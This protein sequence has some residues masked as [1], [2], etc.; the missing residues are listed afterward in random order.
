MRAVSILN[1]AF[2]SAFDSALGSA[3]DRAWR[4]AHFGPSVQLA[5]AQGTWSFPID[6]RETENA[7]LISANLPGV[8]KED[9]QIDV[10]DD[11]VTISAQTKSTALAEAEKCIRR[12]RFEGQYKRQF[13]L[14]QPIDPD[15]VSAKLELGVLELVLPKKAVSNAKR[16]TV[17]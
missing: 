2:D 1:S 3:L 17:E 11:V 7:Y 13:Q 9:I 15:Q 10:E 4:H 5:K 8:A 16:I 14:A 6:A 12:E